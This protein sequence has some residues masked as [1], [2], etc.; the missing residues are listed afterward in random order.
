MHLCSAALPACTI[1]PPPCC[2]LNALL[3][4]DT[5]PWAARMHPYNPLFGGNI[6]I[7][8]VPYFLGWRDGAVW[9]GAMARWRGLGWRDAAGPQGGRE[10]ESAA[11][12]P[13]YFSL[14]LVHTVVYREGS[15]KV[16]AECPLLV[17][18]L[19]NLF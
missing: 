8:H 18:S 13:S 4:L 14:D 16:R 15:T 6:Y 7:C 12:V 9:D 10:V 17:K 19:S 11:A 2:L 1:G 5:A 3:G